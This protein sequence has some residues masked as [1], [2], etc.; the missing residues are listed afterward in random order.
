MQ[1]DIGES[2]SEYGH[3][4]QPW[5]GGE[6]HESQVLTATSLLVSVR[7]RTS[8]QRAELTQDFGICTN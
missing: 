3:I 4:G 5:K 8:I 6:V 2:G 7:P 1:G